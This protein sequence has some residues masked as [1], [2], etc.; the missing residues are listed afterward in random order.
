MPSI[1][2]RNDTSGPVPNSYIV[3]IDP[4]GKRSSWGFYGAPPGLAPSFGPLRRS[5]DQQYSTTTGALQLT[6]PEYVRLKEFIRSSE[7]NPPPYEKDSECSCNAWAITALRI[8]LG[9]DVSP[10]LFAADPREVWKSLIC[11]P[12]QRRTGN[13]K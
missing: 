13:T 10:A 2:L 5:C 4:H 12:I 11:P 7:S 8:T 6:Y 9:I 1:E 3:V